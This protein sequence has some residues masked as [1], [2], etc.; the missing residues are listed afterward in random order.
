MHVL[1]SEQLGQFRAVRG[2]GVVA[3]LAAV[4]VPSRLAREQSASH[5]DPDNL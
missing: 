4:D 5:N 3:R 2:T 1:Q